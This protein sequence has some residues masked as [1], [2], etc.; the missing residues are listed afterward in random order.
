RT[1]DH[2]P[3]V[4]F[5][6]AQSPLGARAPDLQNLE[7]GGGRLSR[8]IERL[9]KLRETGAGL[10]ERQPV[11]L[12]FDTRDQALLRTSSSAR[13]TSCSA[14]FSSVRSFAS[15]AFCSAR[16]LAISPSMFTSSARRSNASRCC[17]CRSNS[18]I[19]SPGSTRVPAFTSPTT[20]RGTIG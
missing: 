17:C 3:G 9:L 11:L 12:G 10:F 15:N 6:V 5:G 18:T 16:F 20:S 13:A 1:H 19:G 7:I 2:E 4:A 14:A 8:E